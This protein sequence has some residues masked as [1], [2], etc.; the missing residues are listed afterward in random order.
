MWRHILR[1]FNMEQLIS[2]FGK[3]GLKMK[4][5]FEIDILTSRSNSVSKV[6]QEKFPGFVS[7]LKVAASTLSPYGPI[8]VDPGIPEVIQIWSTVKK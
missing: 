2:I 4:A 3:Q 5:V 8:N 1:E 6:Y 7:I